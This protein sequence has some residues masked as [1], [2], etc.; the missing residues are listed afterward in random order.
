MHSYGIT[1]M[2]VSTY[3]SATKIK[4]MLDHHPELKQAGLPNLRF[5]TVETWLLFKLC[6]E[7]PFLA[8]VS[9]ASRTNLM[10]LKNCKWAPDM[11]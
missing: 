11:T 9:N 6:Q 4:W 10:S 3:C 1:G 2:R 8:E 5:G 7:H